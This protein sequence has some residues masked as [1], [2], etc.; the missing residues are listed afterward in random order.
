[1]KKQ[2]N[3]LEN[4]RAKNRENQGSSKSERIEKIESFLAKMGRPCS[5]LEVQTGTSIPRHIVRRIFQKSYTM[6]GSEKKM[7]LTGGIN[8]AKSR[9][10]WIRL[11][12]ETLKDGGTNLYEFATTI[13]KSWKV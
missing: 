3:A 11:T 6:A 12:K 9:K 10:G 13:K 7:G 5:A 8:Q 2:E 4:A 1:M